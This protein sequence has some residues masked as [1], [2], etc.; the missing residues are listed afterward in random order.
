MPT[1][2]TRGLILQTNILI[3]N[4]PFPRAC[5]SD[6]GLYAFAATASFGPTRVDAGGTVGFMAPELHSEGAKLSKEADMYAFGMLVYEVIAGAQPYRL[7]KVWEIPMLTVQGWRP[8]KPEAPVPAGF[9]QGTW[10]FAERC[11]DGNPTWRP[12]ARAALKHFG[13]VVKISM[14]VDPGTA[15]RIQEPAG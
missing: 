11:W 15:I 13:R 9:G 1:P 6:F 12:S 4:E 3:V 10:E 8:P 7:H 2:L 5:I 14:V